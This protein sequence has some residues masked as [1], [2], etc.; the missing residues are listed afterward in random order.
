MSERRGRGAAPFVSR[1]A[2]ARASPKVACSALVW[3]PTLV[4]AKL[5]RRT[6]YQ[7]RHTFASN[8]L[9]AGGGAVVG[10]GDVGARE[11]RDAVLRS[12]A[13]F[14]PHRTRRDGSAL[15]NRMDGAGERGAERKEGRMILPKYS[16]ARRGT[17]TR[18]TAVPA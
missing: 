13:R 6:M 16:R 15:V 18:S 2:V 11:L 3:Y 7:T 12:Y 8:A 17:P 10:G 14:I 5:G 4:K 1:A 9:A